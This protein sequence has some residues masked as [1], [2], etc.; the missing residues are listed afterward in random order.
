MNSTTATGN[1]MSN[2]NAA[3]A[4][5]IKTLDAVAVCKALGIDSR[6]AAMY[7][8]EATTEAH[9]AIMEYH[10]GRIVDAMHITARAQA[11][12]GEFCRAS[13]LGGMDHHISTIMDCLLADITA[14]H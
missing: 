4:A 11:M 13:G 2:F 1:D 14:A 6:E 8:K 12:A 3:H 10:D 7:A 5:Y 9:L